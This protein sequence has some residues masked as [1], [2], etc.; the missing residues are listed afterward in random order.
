MSAKRTKPTKSSDT[1]EIGFDHDF[2]DEAFDLA[3]LSARGPLAIITVVLERAT[4]DVTVN[5]TQS[6]PMETLGM[7][8]AALQYARLEYEGAG[9]LEGT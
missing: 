4:G 6:T 9:E 1:V 7:L 5:D 8:D 3:A 2:D